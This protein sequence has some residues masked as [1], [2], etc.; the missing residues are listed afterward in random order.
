MFL[1][2][3]GNL[4]EKDNATTALIMYQEM[5]YQIYTNGIHFMSEGIEQKEIEAQLTQIEE[6]MENDTI[7]FERKTNERIQKL[8]EQLVDYV[9]LAYE[10]INVT[11]DE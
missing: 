1:L 9:K 7:T 5:A 2:L 4:A 3:E 10:N 6:Q 11:I 8:Y